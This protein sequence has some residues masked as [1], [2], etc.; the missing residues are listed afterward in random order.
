MH[1]L[2]YINF[3]NILYFHFISAR[4]SWKRRTPLN[5]HDNSIY[6]SNTKNKVAIYYT[7]STPY[8]II[9]AAWLP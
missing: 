9:H 5:K 1:Y 3:S 6:S 2:N 4:K 7:K 8:A